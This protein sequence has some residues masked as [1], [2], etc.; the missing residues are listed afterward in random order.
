MVSRSV[1]YLKQTRSH[2]KHCVC[3][4]HDHFDVILMICDSCSVKVKRSKDKGL[5]SQDRMRYD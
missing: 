5:K 2:A 1:Q 3:A 4:M